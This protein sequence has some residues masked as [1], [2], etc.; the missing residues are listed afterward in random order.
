MPKPSWMRT[1]QRA[2]VWLWASITWPQV[3]AW[4]LR[5]QHLDPPGGVGAVEVVRRLAGVQAQVASA[6]ELAIRIRQLAP[7]R[8]EV[9]RALV[10]DRS[11]VNASAAATPRA[12]PLPRRPHLV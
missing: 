8:D 3:L 4:R 2:R 10:E 9:R 11:L 6:A 12:C 7:A 5:R 1:V